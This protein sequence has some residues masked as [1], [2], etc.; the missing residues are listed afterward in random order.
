[1]FRSCWLWFMW[2]RGAEHSQ[3][4]WSYDV[5]E[6][7]PSV[8]PWSFEDPFPDNMAFL[9]T[10]SSFLRSRWVLG[11]KRAFPKSN[12]MEYI[13]TKLGDVLPGIGVQSVSEIFVLAGMFCD[14]SGALWFS[15]VL[16][17]SA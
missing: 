17:S 8:C 14:I 12:A 3:P 2:R 7:P 6:L 15:P 5:P 4:L 11:A 16:R 9:S 13:W 10:F 1:M